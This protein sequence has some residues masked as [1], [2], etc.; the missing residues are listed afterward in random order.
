MAVYTAA[1]LPTY[2]GE[3]SGKSLTA[4]ELIRFHYTSLKVFARGSTVAFAL[5]ASFYK[6]EN[7]CYWLFG[8]RPGVTPSYSNILVERG[9]A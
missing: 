7:R 2:T 3:F 5:S 8:E 6:E 1:L 4:S 9:T